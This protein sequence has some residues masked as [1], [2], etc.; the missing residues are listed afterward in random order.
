MSDNERC[1]QSSQHEGRCRLAFPHT[2]PHFWEGA[3]V[4]P[5]PFF[6]AP[7]VPATHEGPTGAS[8]ASHALTAPADVGSG[9][10]PA[11]EREAAMLSREELEKHLLGS[12][13]CLGAEDEAIVLAHDAAQRAEI[14]GLRTAVDIEVELRTMAEATVKDYLQLR[15]IIGAAPHSGNCAVRCANPNLRTK[16]GAGRG[17][18]CDCFK[19]KGAALRERVRELEGK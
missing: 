7:E 12:E 4:P 11:G 3:A 8:G 5:P 17:S 9:K 2:G 19:A 1:A 15:D 18:A 16:R 13:P 6:V 14:V 10:K